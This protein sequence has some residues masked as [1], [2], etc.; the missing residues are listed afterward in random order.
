M[1]SRFKCETCSPRHTHAD[2]TARHRG[3]L[4]LQRASAQ[5]SVLGTDQMLWGTACAAVAHEASRGMDMVRDFIPRQQQR[6]T[7]GQQTSLAEHGGVVL[8]GHT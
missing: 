4:K 7:C 3:L 1:L 5:G 2:G 8:R 6:M